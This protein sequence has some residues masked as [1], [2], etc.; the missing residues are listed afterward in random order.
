MARKAPIMADKSA[1]KAKVRDRIVDEAARALRAGGT[2]GLSVANLMQRAG[3]THGG[4]YAH[5]ENR[6][7]LVVHAIDRMFEDS[8]AMLARF[9]PDGAGPAGVAAL[10][11][12]YLSDRAM[13]LHDRGCPLPWLS[14][15]VPRMPAPA[16]ARFR[17]GI[18]AMRTAIARE[19]QP[20]GHDDPAAATLAASVVAEMVGAMALARALGE[21]AQASAILAAARSAIRN[22]LAAPADR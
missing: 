11:D 17:A 21:N 1:H 4:F 3:L 8:A 22:R 6:D 15:E 18:A 9:L 5:F 13:R 16:Q 19:L 20:D 12:N 2:E 10:V 7:D 14:G